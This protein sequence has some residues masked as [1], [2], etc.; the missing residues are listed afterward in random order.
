VKALVDDLGGVESFIEKWSMAS[1]D[2]EDA[3]HKSTVSRW[4]RGQWPKDRE[5]FLRLSDVLDVD[6]FALIAIRESDPQT[7]ADQILDIVQSGRSIP[8]IISLLH[9]FFGR[10]KT[11]PPRLEGLP[12]SWYSREFHHDPEIRSN[13]YACIHLMGDSV[14]M[15]KRPQVFHFAFRNTRRFG[16]RWLQYG[17]V[18]RYGI[19]STL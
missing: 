12:R 11:W 10:Q 3:P 6:P 14:H 17:L 5:T 15:K 19:A 4:N 16:G 18:L 8:P 13:F 9:P 7:A 2:G 1:V